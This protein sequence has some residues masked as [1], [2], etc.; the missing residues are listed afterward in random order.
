ML[1]TSYFRPP[2]FRPGR[3][4]KGSERVFRRPLKRALGADKKRN[5]FCGVRQ[6]GG[7]IFAQCHM[8]IVFLFPSCTLLRRQPQHI[9]CLEHIGSIV[10]GSGERT[11]HSTLHPRPVASIACKTRPSSSTV[12]RGCYSLHSRPIFFIVCLYVLLRRLDVLR[13]LL[14]CIVS[15]SAAIKHMKRQP[16]S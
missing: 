11:F 14:R 6:T 2:G 1:L 10:V 12:R 15:G 5:S 8:T 7:R 16:A 13:A 9:F 3:A 4:P